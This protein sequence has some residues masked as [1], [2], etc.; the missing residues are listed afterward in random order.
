MAAESFDRQRFRDVVIVG[1]G[2]YGAFY[3]RQLERAHARGKIDFRRIIVVDQDP[4]CRVVRELGASG[5]RRVAVAE[6]GAF[7]DQ[8]LNGGAS[9]GDAGV[10]SPLMP[11]LM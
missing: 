8:W 3:A 5:T 11:P 7:F 10:P 9:G 2:C 6:W 4:Q 1:G